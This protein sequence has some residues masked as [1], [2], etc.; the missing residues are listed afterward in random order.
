MN[1]YF[2]PLEAIMIDD[3]NKN[4]LAFCIEFIRTHFREHSQQAQCRTWLKT[5]I[6]ILEN[7]PEVSSGNFIISEMTDIDK[8][9]A[10]SDS[11]STS[12]D[13]FSKL[14]MIDTLLKDI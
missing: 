8:W 5:A 11:K 12:E 3:S 2:I 14:D 7:A 10:G 9:L 6:S 1:L 13:M 4:T